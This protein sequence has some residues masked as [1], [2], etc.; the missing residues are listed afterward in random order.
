MSDSSPHTAAI[1]I[2]EATKQH[3][4]HKGVFADLTPL[5]QSPAFA[6]LWIGSSL[7][8]IGAQMTLMTVALEIFDITQ[9]TFY[10]GL[11]AMFALL[12]ALIAGIYAGSL[13]DAFDRRLVSLYS[14]VASWITIGA[15]A[16]LAWMDVRNIW[17]LYVLMAINSASATVNG[18]ARKAIVPRLIRPKLLPAANALTGI[19]MGAMLTIGPAVGAIVVALWGFA[20]AYTID[21]FLFSFAFF[22]IVT[23]PPLPPSEHAE[24]P[25]LRSVWN[26]LVWLKNAP[27]IRSGFIVD[28]IAMGFAMPRVLFPALGLVVFGG[29]ATTVGV[30][31]AGMAIGTLVG[32]LFSGPLGRVRWQ[33]KAIIWAVF[34]YGLCIALFGIS[35]FGA[36]QTPLQDGEV[37][38]IWIGV[39]M[40][41]L[42]GSGVMDNISAVFRNAM[43]QTAAPDEMIGRLGGVY[44]VVVTGGPRVGDFIYGS[45]AAL[46]LWFPPLFGGVLCA[47]LMVLFLRSK[48]ANYDGD[49]PT[50]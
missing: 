17:A 8:G 18:V 27:N 46:A 13:S 31:T 6:R 37:K 45:L 29:G 26:G 22:G 21:V 19:S 39:G 2:S 20:P 11:T 33:G 35:V 25:G 47:A 1:D 3:K 48:L 44:I 14:A 36:M 38:W 9:D 32:G 4:A 24:A 10:V 23:L 16:A 30:L 43:T 34:G 12:P 41:G 15:I 7:S 28:I 42:I 50:P 40:L 49:N 5:K